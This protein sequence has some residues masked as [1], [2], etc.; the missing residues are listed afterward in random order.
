MPANPALPPAYEDVWITRFGSMIADSVVKAVGR[1]LSPAPP[2]RPSTSN[3]P[4]LEGFST[5]AASPSSNMPK[6]VEPVVFDAMRKL[7]PDGR[8]RSPEQ[9]MAAQLAWENQ[10]HVLAVLPTGGGK[11][12]IAQVAAMLDRMESR[13]NIILVPLKSLADDLTERLSKS[14]IMV[15][16]FRGRDTPF[17]Q[18]VIA[19]FEDAGKPHFSEYI[20][21]RIETKTMGRLIVDECHYPVYAGDFRPGMA[22]LSTLVIHG[23][24]L[25]LLSATVP[26]TE[27]RKVLDFYGTPRASIVRAPTSRPN[28]KYVVEKLPSRPSG[29]SE[30]TF[31]YQQIKKA[32][33]THR[34]ASGSRVLIY[35]MSK[36]LI[37]ALIEEQAMEAASTGE[38]RWSKYHADMTD[39]EKDISLS[40]WCQIMLATD[41]LGLGTDLQRCW[42]VLHYEAPFTILD[43]VQQTGRA[44]R[45]GEPSV[46]VLLWSR[47]MVVASSLDHGRVLMS[48]LLESTLCRRWIISGFMDGGGPSCLSLPESYGLCDNCTLALQEYKRKNKVPPPPNNAGLEITRIT[49]L[50]DQ[51]SP[52][53]QMRKLWP[54]L[55][56]L[57]EVCLRCYMEGMPHPSHSLQMWNHPDGKYLREQLQL[58]I[59]WR[60]SFKTPSGYAAHLCSMCWLPS[61][62]ERYHRPASLSDKPG[63]S[64]KYNDILRPLAYAAF[65]REEILAEFSAFQQCD[66]W[67]TREEWKN[68]L[69][70]INKVQNPRLYD[71]VIWFD[72]RQSTIPGNWTARGRSGEPYN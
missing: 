72:E 43:Y 49:T 6:L 71:F 52:D 5:P 1:S 4:N 64:C 53:A 45:D 35:I 61:H 69:L 54:I 19:I 16:R 2:A 11:T 62:G 57:R 15:E 41:A 24:Q 17:A 42:M 36:Q 13:V 38:A 14:D 67:S 18:V 56:G 28:I 65:A 27:T 63:K 47:R 46:A 9:A 7:M 50:P 60:R 55:T 70:G 20:R 32:I 30:V 21:T 31:A 23:I 22:S 48:S 26:V 25:V 66:P 59:E 51:P 12:L 3:S 10:T 40:K 68:W 29:L 34:P 33:A 44:G 8:F 39:S 37:D 58:Y